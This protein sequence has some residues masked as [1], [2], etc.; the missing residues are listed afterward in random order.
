MCSSDLI[1]FLMKL[2][3]QMF[4]KEVKKLHEEGV[5]VRTIGDLSRFD[6]DIQD[7]VAEWVEKTKDNQEI[8]VIFALNYGGRDE[9]LRAVQKAAQDLGQDE[10]AKRKLEQAEFAQYLDTADFPDP[11]L[12]IRPGKEV[13]LSGYLLWQS[14]Y[15]EL[16]FT[17]V[18]MPDFDG[19]ELEK[20]IKE[21]NRRQRNFGK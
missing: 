5:R 13:R 17:D 6:Q 7:S 19:A 1:K 15:S 16:Y 11:E 2:F 20:A 4:S 9:L 18:M 10:L 8:T 21:L 14:N 3:R 12:I